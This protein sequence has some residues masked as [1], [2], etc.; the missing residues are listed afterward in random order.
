MADG[1]AG[2]PL[3]NDDFRKLMMTPRPGQQP[4]QQQAMGME[5]KQKS[6]TPRPVKPPPKFSAKKKGEGDDGK[7]EP[8]YRYYARLVCCGGC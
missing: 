1:Q 8:G 7:D 4:R 5:K 6:K 3:S 2:R